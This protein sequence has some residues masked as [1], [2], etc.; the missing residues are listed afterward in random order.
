M[1]ANIIQKSNF[2]DKATYPKV[3]FEKV[4]TEK[5]CQVSEVVLGKWR[6]ELPAVLELLD[7]E[8]G[9]TWDKTQAAPARPHFRKVDEVVQAVISKTTDVDLFDIEELEVANDSM[10]LVNVTSHK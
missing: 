10:V 2:A 9:P 8:M 1:G 7:T 5:N 3:H 6:P 4:K